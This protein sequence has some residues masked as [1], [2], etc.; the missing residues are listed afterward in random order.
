[1]STSDAWSQRLRDLQ[2]NMGA[3]LQPMA[4]GLQTFRDEV[5]ACASPLSRAEGLLVLYGQPASMQQYDQAMADLRLARQTFCANKRQHE[6]NQ[7]LVLIAACLRLRGHMQACFAVTERAL[8]SQ[9][10]AS[11]QRMQLALYG[12]QAL[13]S[14]LRYDEADHWAQH[15]ILSVLGAAP[16]RPEHL[17][18]WLALGFF[19]LQQQARALNNQTSITLDIPPE[20]PPNEAAALAY[21]AEARVCLARAS[22][23]AESEI[24]RERTQLLEMA[25]L[26][27]EGQL[28]AAT[29]VYENLKQCWREKPPHY[30]GGL[31][32]N[33]GNVLKVCGSDAQAYQALS[34]AAELGERHGLGFVHGATY[35]L[36]RLAQALGR[37]EAAMTHYARFMVLNHDLQRTTYQW[38][39]DQD[40][41]ATFGQAPEAAVPQH[42]ARLVESKPPYLQ[43]AEKLVLQNLAQPL[44]MDELAKRVKVSRRTLEAAMKKYENMSPLAWVRHQRMAHAAH[45][46]QHTD[47]PLKAV[48]QDLGYAHVSSFIRDFK[49]V[50]GELPSQRKKHFMD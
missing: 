43:Q 30:V 15:Y 50:F 29:A 10:L 46:L 39:T 17:D 25:V 40:D 38:F 26:G 4:Q 16:A 35:S 34:R 21:L 23:C 37:H 28:R 36:A 42:P 48:A 6:E 45:L 31:E 7:C 3:A 1:M 19:R 47:A 8:K 12:L 18:F 49:K 13:A 14:L 5:L 33:F 44:K 41:L 27:C 20:R 11:T 2:M 9:A 24:N 22:S 32:I